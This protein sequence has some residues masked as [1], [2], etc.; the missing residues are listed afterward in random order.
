MLLSRFNTKEWQR[1]LS[2][3][4][5][6]LIFA[7]GDRVKDE[8]FAFTKEGQSR[9]DIQNHLLKDEIDGGFYQYYLSEAKTFAWK[10]RLA[11]DVFAGRK[12]EEQI[13]QE[14]KTRHHD[15]VK[16]GLDALEQLM[17]KEGYTFHQAF[18]FLMDVPLEFW[19]KEVKR[20]SS[21]KPST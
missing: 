4:F 18:I 12:W 6:Q 7:Y 10:A 19:G 13:L 15:L 17:E 3:Y 9:K 2:Q 5:D 21:L 11:V 20:L 8:M 1:L 14:V 16:Q